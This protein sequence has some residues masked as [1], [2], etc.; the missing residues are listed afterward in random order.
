[1]PEGIKTGIFFDNGLSEEGLLQFN[2]DLERLLNKK[3]NGIN[4]IEQLLIEVKVSDEGKPVL[5]RVG[6]WDKSENGYHTNK[7]PQDYSVEDIANLD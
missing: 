5:Y 2:S 6:K 7:D 4:V 3:Y 1:M